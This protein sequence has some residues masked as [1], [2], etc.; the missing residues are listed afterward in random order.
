MD[1]EKQKASVGDLITEA[2]LNESYNA[3]EGILKKL[4][5]PKKIFVYGAGGWGRSL[6][7][8]LGEYGIAVQAFFDKQADEIKRVDRTPVFSL[9]QYEGSEEEKK[10]ALVIIAVRVEIQEAVGSLLTENGFVNWMSMNG[11]WHYGCWSSRQELFSLIKEKDKILC[12]SD[13]WSDSRS[14][15]VYYSC[16]ACYVTRQHNTTS[17]IDPDQYFPDDIKLQKGYAN[18][19]DCGAYT[20]DT[21]D[22]LPVH[23]EK[24]NKIVAFEPDPEN[25][26]R[27]EANIAQSKSSLA[28]SISLYPN[29]LWSSSQILFFDHA[30]G[31]NGHLSCSGSRTALKFVALDEVLLNWD[32]TFIKMDIE[33][34]EVEAIKGAANIIRRY[35][36]DLAISVYHEIGHLWQIP[37]LLSEINR[38]YRYYLRAHEHFNQE[39]VLYAVTK[40]KDS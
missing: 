13:F 20:G 11:I 18:F 30:Q 17:R 24:V 2:S 9:D 35:K 34:A 6:C 38:D 29:G 27:L 33:G 8:L 7:R 14:L 37:L 28:E 15:N 26:K 10:G 31:H 23:V 1:T 25:F 4:K 22:A 5:Q 21:L 36:P 12:V 32:P 40:G 16:I 39:I 3:F 19:I